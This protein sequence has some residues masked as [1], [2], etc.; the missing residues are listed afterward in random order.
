MPPRRSRKSESELHKGAVEM[1][2][3][4]IGEMIREGNLDVG[5]RLQSERDLAK[6]FGI[7]RPA[8]REAARA[9]SIMG[10]LETRRG[11]GSYVVS[12]L[13]DIP[14]WPARIM[15]DDSSIPLLQLLEVRQIFEPK[16]AALAA[17]RATD[18]QL[19]RIE[20]HLLTQES[21][22]TRQ[23][24]EREDL[25]FHQAII[26][27]AG[28]P[29]LGDL[30]AGMRTMLRLSRKL[31]ARTTPDIPKIIRQHRTIF[32]AVSLGQS[33]LAEAAMA[34]HLRAVGLDIISE[35]AR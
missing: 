27:A 9:L 2:I 33:E 22:P 18:G 15:L 3:L 11:S 13:A 14:D 16:A 12:R 21:S 34:Q 19:Q 7:G 20:S 35:V 32:E 5:A 1:A 25:L 26:E 28:N 31:T 4:R 23:V 8:L 10:V 6:R 29:V 24:L 17:S 30:A